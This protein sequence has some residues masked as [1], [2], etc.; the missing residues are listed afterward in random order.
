M[1]KKLAASII[2]ALVAALTSVCTTSAQ[3]QDPNTLPPSGNLSTS[4]KSGAASA[5]IPQPFGGEDVSGDLL[6]PITGS[7]SR[8]SRD[9]WSMKVF[10]NTK[11]EY[12]VDVDVLQL[13]TSGQRVKTD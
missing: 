3:I 13:N 2:V 4:L 1:A 6:P 5:E 8:V 12:S 7:V 11:D 9:A 10:N